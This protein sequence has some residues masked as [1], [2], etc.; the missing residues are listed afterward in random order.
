MSDIFDDCKL[1]ISPDGGTNDWDEHQALHE[2]GIDC[3]VLDHHLVEDPDMI[4]SDPALIVNIQL[5]DYPNKAL[6]GA[7]VAYKFI[8]AF[9]D[10]YV[11][12][13]QPDEFMDLCAIGIELLLC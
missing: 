6:T 7:G 4:D 13:N 1:V 3:L 10:L 5:E 2:L 8:S 9:E 11:H 12:G